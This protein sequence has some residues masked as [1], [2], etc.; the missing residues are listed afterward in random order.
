MVVF[1]K[2]IVDVIVREDETIMDYHVPL[3]R[4]LKSQLWPKQCKTIFANNIN[5]Y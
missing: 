5:M 1:P 3:G 4:G 2:K